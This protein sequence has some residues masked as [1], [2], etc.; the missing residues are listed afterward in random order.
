LFGR[1]GMVEL[2]MT[3]GDYVMTAILLNAVNQQVPADR[4]FNLPIE[5]K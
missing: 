3:L 1:Q 2:T 5:K 4:P